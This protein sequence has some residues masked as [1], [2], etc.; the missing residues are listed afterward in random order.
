MDLPCS[1]RARMTGQ[2]GDWSRIPPSGLGRLLAALAI[3][4]VAFSLLDHAAVRESQAD[5]G[6]TPSYVSAR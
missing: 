5:A 4:V 6:V 3:I 1:T 2:T